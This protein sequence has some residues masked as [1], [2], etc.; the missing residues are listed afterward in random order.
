[1]NSKNEF[2]L[3]L[4]LSAFG[5]AVFFFGSLTAIGL[6]SAIPAVGLLIAGIVTGRKT[7]TLANNDN[8][9]DKS[10]SNTA[11]A[12]AVIGIVLIAIMI[13]VCISYIIAKESEKTRE[14]ANNA[15]SSYW[16]DLEDILS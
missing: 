4:S 7:R 10:A 15:W 2:V 8:A 13:I 6:Y 9:I 1:M 12:V 5:I 16:S 11:V 3:S 14:L